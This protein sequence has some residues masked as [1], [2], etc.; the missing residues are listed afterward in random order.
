M[1]GANAAIEGISVFYPNQ[2]ISSTPV[3]YPF[4]IQGN[5]FNLALR[6]VLLVNSYQGIDFA[7]YQCARHYVDGIYGQV[8]T[9]IDYY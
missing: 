3:E 4:T 9:S 5:G 1:A 8:R 7:T 2:V 6:N